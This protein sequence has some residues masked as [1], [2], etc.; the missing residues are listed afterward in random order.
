MDKRGRTVGQTWSELAVSNAGFRQ[1]LQALQFVMEWGMVTAM[2]GREPET[3]DEYA[4][5]AEVSR[6]KAFRDQKAFRKAYPG[7]SGPGQMV[8][9]S[10]GQEVFEDFIR[11]AKDLGNARRNSASFVFQL[12][13]LP[14]NSAG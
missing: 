7:L 9:Q 4:E 5:V 14:V 10:C 1:G 11:T 3:I 13:A 6:A 8:A 12:G 2:L